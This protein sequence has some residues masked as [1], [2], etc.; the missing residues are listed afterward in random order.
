MRREDLPP[1]LGPVGYGLLVSLVTV[2]AAALVATFLLFIGL[3]WARYLHF[4]GL[5]IAFASVALGGVL[6]GARAG[7]RGWLVGL[8]TSVCFVLVCFLLAVITGA[9][10]IIA[11]LT[12]A[13]L[14]IACALG[15]LGGALGVG[16]AS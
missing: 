7:S 4:V 8:L 15:A 10:G 5:S 16:F 3:D 1:I 14:A 12:F 6:A 13:R 9:K 2:I 11:S